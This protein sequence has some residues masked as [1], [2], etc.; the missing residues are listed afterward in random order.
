MEMIANLPL[1]I[2]MI[3]FREIVSLNAISKDMKA[4][5]QNKWFNLFYDKA[6]QLIHACQYDQ[7]MDIVLFLRNT[8]SEK[9]MKSEF[10]N[11]I[12]LIQI[13]YQISRQIMEIFERPS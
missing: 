1:E 3:I 7:C 8:V 6:W 12:E 5:L 4:E 9:D 10:H 2:R 13:T 11:R